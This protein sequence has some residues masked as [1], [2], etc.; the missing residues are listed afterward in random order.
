MLGWL[1]EEEDNSRVIDPFPSEEGR[2][3]RLQLIF[4]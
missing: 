4:K 3:V 2:K 1:R